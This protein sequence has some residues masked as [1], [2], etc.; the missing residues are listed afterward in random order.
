MSSI[1]ELINRR[2]IDGLVQE[3][4]IP[5]DEILEV[6]F[7]YKKFKLMAKFLHALGSQVEYIQPWTFV[8]KILH[9][10]RTLAEDVID[11][12]YNPD[13][14]LWFERNEEEVLWLLEHG[15]D[16]NVTFNNISAL[17]CRTMEGNID[18][19]RLLLTWGAEPTDVTIRYAVRNNHVDLVKQMVYTQK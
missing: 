4:Y 15:A 18:V 16:P 5:L 6:M 2:D 9:L 12:G 8:Q 14:A 10:D 13:Q 17:E 11:Q 1:L 3:R 7:R 19:A